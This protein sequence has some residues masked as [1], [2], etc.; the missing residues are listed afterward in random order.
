VWQSFINEMDLLPKSV[1]V[2]MSPLKL[3]EL[4]DPVAAVPEER[5]VAATPPPLN[6]KMSSAGGKRPGTQGSDRVGGRSLTVRLACH[7]SVAL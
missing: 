5:R 1:R 6:R 3:S 7:S 2:M 4:W